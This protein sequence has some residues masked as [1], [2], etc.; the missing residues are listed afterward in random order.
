MKHFEHK[1]T[2][3]NQNKG[4]RGKPASV[5][6]SQAIDAMRDS[7]VDSPKKSHHWCSLELGIKLTS[8]WCILTKELKILPDISMRHKLRQNNM[9]RR[10]D[11]CNWLSDRKE[12]ITNWINDE[13]HFHLNVP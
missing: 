10:L 13:A 9:R 11:M 1:G 7:A 4:N 8:V 6:E 5:T 12:W 2:V 3:H